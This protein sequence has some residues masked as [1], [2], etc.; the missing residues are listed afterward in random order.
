MSPWWLVVAFA[1][2]RSGVQ[3][4]R[5]RREAGA[6]R[7][8]TGVPGQPVAPLDRVPFPHAR[9]AFLF[10]RQSFARDDWRRAPL[11]L[12]C[13]L[14]PPWIWALVWVVPTVQSRAA[15]GRWIAIERFRLAVP[16]R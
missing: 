9:I 16:A 4:G 8:P 14:L 11:E 1:R 12:F 10:P 5:G 3:A 2:R 13:R 15:S 7:R 6:K